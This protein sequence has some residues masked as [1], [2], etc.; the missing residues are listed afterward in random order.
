MVVL[1]AGCHQYVNPW[2]DE[3]PGPEA[4]TTASV[5]SIRELG[6]TP[7]L[8][9]RSHE[10]MAISPQDGTVPHFPLWFEDAFESE[11]SNDGQFALTWEDYLAMPWSYGRMHLNTIALPI[12]A[13]AQPPVPYMGSDGVL[14]PRAFGEEHDAEWLGARGTALPPDIVELGEVP[15]PVRATNLEPAAPDPAATSGA[16]SK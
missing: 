9:Q 16:D 3:Y 10:P 2:V 5:T 12:S 6:A 15:Q 11:G 13:I 8:R 1:V 7:A 14:S 4:V